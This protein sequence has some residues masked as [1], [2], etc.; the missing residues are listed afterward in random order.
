MPLPNL[1]DRSLVNTSQHSTQSATDSFQSGGTSYR[2]IIK[3]KILNTPR[4]N[5]DHNRRS[6]DL[7]INRENNY[8]SS[9]RLSY[10][11]RNKDDESNLENA[12]EWATKN[13]NGS[14]SSRRRQ[15]VFYNKTYVP[16]EEDGVQ[17]QNETV[18]QHDDSFKSNRKEA[19]NSLNTS[20]P[21][22]S[23]RREKSHT[24]SDNRETDK[25]ERRKRFENSRP[26]SIE[27][28]YNNE[29][30]S[31]DN[32]EIRGERNQKSGY[33]PRRGANQRDNQ[34][35]TSPFP[36]L[37][38]SSSIDFNHNK[39]TN[40]TNNLNRSYHQNDSDTNTRPANTPSVKRRSFTAINNNN[41]TRERKSNIFSDLN[42]PSSTD[43]D[44]YQ[45]QN[46]N[47]IENDENF[48]TQSRAAPVVTRRNNKNTS[49]NPLNRNS[50]TD[51]NHF[52]NN[53]QNNKEFDKHDS[54]SSNDFNLRSTSR[55]SFRDD[56]EYIQTRSDTPKNNKNHPIPT[57]RKR[58]ENV[59]SQQ[60]AKSSLNIENSNDFRIRRFTA[61]TNNRGAV[62]VTAPSRISSYTPS[63]PRLNNA[64][65]NNQ[66]NN[67]DKES[68][69][70]SSSQSI[71]YQR[72][73]SAIS[74]P[75]EL[76]ES[77]I[78]S[79][80][81]SSLNHYSNSKT[82]R[83]NSNES[84]NFIENDN[85]YKHSLHRNSKKNNFLN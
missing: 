29:D 51:M 21:I 42:S 47:K 22:N 49:F 38:S 6:I 40:K 1:R 43:L 24:N 27:T 68:D 80:R 72:Q 70:S 54:K 84:N 74:K 69:N 4:Q 46:S 37:N 7:S 82:N 33:V 20:L 71:K 59:S 11:Y 9:S 78:N 52:N 13:N 5:A 81:L 61:G 36:E 66:N 55:T 16:S 19:K 26:N 64:N 25:E 3:E 75:N 10:A 30:N 67:A 35:N 76:Y 73:K 32:I 8:R 63:S 83:A 17:D 15:V 62:L 85:D 23:S 60:Q 79:G 18:N 2:E 56:E 44:N 31:D 45:Y 53:Q 58:F 77:R 39:N 12:I 14:L 57:P 48:N 34:R 50:L 28:N 41:L 65:F